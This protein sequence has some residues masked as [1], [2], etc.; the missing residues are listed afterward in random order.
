[1][2]LFVKIGNGLKQKAV[3]YFRKSPVLDVRLGSGYT[4]VAYNFV[5]F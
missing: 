2:E 3:S 5:N 4:S 1:M